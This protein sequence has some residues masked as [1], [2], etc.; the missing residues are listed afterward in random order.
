MELDLFLI[1]GDRATRVA[2][3]FREEREVE[4]RQANV[5]LLVDCRADL[6]FSAGQIPSLQRDH[7]EGVARGGELWFD[8]Q[9]VAKLLLG[10]GKVS[11]IEENLGN[12]VP[13]LR[14]PGI[15]L[16]KPPEANQRF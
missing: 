3:F 11:A 6:L 9:R 2:A 13:H 1:L 14:I 7:A 4:V 16:E 15:Q 10:A 12:G 8:R 5:L